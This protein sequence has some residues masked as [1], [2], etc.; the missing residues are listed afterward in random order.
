MEVMYQVLRELLRLWTGKYPVPPHV[1][2]VSHTP[3]DEDVM[4]E[5]EPQE[6][7][8]DTVVEYGL[9]TPAGNV[10][11]N[12]FHGRTFETLYARAMMV[13][14]L[15]KTAEECGFAEDD[16]LSRYR[17]QVRRVVTETVSGGQFPIEDPEIV[18]TAEEES[19]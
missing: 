5:E 16:F 14:V 18:G 11:W 17:W 1:M 15:K 12:R 4:F 7:V 2:P 3:D 9:L 8:K 6:V 19:E 10:L 13:K